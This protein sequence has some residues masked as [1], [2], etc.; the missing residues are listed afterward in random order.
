MFVEKENPQHNEMFPF[1]VSFSD[2]FLFLDKTGWNLL[3]Y[4]KVDSN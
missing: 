3:K 2:V 4:R 1:E